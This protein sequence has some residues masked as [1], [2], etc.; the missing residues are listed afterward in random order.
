MGSGIAQAASQAGFGVR[1]RD[2]SAAQL[3]RGRSLLAK[4]LEGG[5]QRGKL[6]EARRQEILGRIAFTTDLSEAVRDSA[7]V[8]EAVFEEEAVK[9]E[10]LREL[11]PLLGAETIVATNTSSLSVGRLAESVPDPGRFAGL[12]F[13]Y[14]AAIN[15]LL[16]VV[17]GERTR[18]EILDALEGFGYRLRKIPIRVRDSAGF[19]VNRFFVPYLNEATRMA[20]EGLANMATIEKVGRELFGTTLGPFELLNVTGTTIGYHSEQSLSA[21]FGPAYAPSGR[22]EAQFRAG[23]PWDWKSAPV[24]PERV[25]AVRERFLG[26]VF[27]IATELVA[28]G[29][30]S[31]EATDR[32]AVVGLRWAK[33]PFTLLSET[34]LPEGLRMVEAYAARWPGNFPVSAE[35]RRRV[36]A[37]EARWPLA[38]VRVER[39]GAVAWVLLDRPEVMNALNGEMVRQLESAFSGLAGDPGVRAVVL[40]GSSPVFA[41]GADIAEMAAKNVTEGR[42]FGFAGQAVCQ[43]IESFDAPVIALVEGYALGGGLELALACDF[44]VA[45]D[46]ARLG[47]PEVTLGIHTGFGGASRLAKRV[48]RATAKYLV[49]TGAVIGTEEACRLGV[50]TRSVSAE[51]AR[52]TAREIAEGIARNAPLAVR[53]AKA[54]VNHAED[55][56]LGAALRLEGE[57]AGH[58]FATDDRTEGMKAFLERRKP[59]FTGR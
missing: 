41:S 17:G 1:V 43:R 4:T 36:E 16:E 38:C 39:E 3:E 53:W 12:H 25:P 37:G 21:A 29:V 13:F 54:V 56:A 31:A 33:G 50:V 18:P 15:R 2:V 51:S 47:L 5:V 48:G 46:D 22:L 11:G 19:A 23:T 57:S 28:Q 8:I 10:L 58:T 24:E 20:E 45:A 30:A 26:L 14:P 59:T 40:A 6:T 49:L 42:E 7:L 9:R 44:I 34:G 55:V 27:G 32:A 52:Q 35:L